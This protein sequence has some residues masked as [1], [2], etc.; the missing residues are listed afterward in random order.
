MELPSKDK[1]GNSY[2]SYSQI[3]LFLKDKEQYKKQYILKEPFVGNEYTDFGLKVGK[4][5]ESGNFELFDKNEKETLSKVTRLDLFERKT[6]LKY[7]DFYII[8]FIDTC[9]NDLTEII[10]YKTGGKNK[11]FEYQ[12]DDYTQLLYYALSLR[13]ETGITPKKA[14]VEFI[15]REGNLYRNQMLKVGKEE[16]I[17]IEVDISE[18]RLKKVYWETIEIAKNISEF[19]LHNNKI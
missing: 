8:G 15:R 1:F 2:L 4:A 16:P 13:Q 6:I 5:L 11:E 19:Y 3:S 7:E 12:K 14:S 18:N 10:D 17:K 9:N